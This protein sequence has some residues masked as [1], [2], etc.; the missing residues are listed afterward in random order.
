[1]IYGLL[2]VVVLMVPFGSYHSI[3]EPNIT[4]VLWGYQLPVGYVSLLC[5]LAVILYPKLSVLKGRLDFVVVM[6]GLVLLVSLSLSSKDFFIN[7]INNTT[8]GASQIDI[9][10]AVGNFVVWGLSLFSLALGFAL[11]AGLFRSASEGT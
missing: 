11:R 1:M 2:L 4:G 6:I 3:I 8:L 7:L 10:N 9:D 5:G